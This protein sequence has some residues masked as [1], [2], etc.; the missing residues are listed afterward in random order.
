MTLDLLDDAFLRRWQARDQRTVP[1]PAAMGDTANGGMA[2]ASVPATS[3]SRPRPRPRADVPP[4]R[5]VSLGPWASLL[6]Q[7][8]PT[9]P[10]ISDAHD[11]NAFTSDGGR[12]EANARRLFERAPEQWLALARHVER[13]RQRGL[14]VIAVAGGERGEGRSTLLACLAEALR[15]RDH[16][17]VC[18]E[19]AD[20]EH[21]AGGPVGGGVPH[22]KRIVLVDAGIWFPPGPIQRRRLLFTSLGHDAVIL[23]RRAGRPSLEARAAALESLGIVVLGEVLTFA[24][25]ED[26]DGRRSEAGA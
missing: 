4:R 1:A 9:T 17:V 20:V 12:L 19:P 25:P 11:G 6:R 18:V 21:A 26:C 3:A 7:P 23:V 5:P 13:A 24:T 14:R 2:T 10:T 16:D 22:D 8:A 15:Q